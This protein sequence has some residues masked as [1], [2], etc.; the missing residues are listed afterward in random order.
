M[1]HMAQQPVLK[2]TALWSPYLG[3]IYTPLKTRP[4]DFPPVEYPPVVCKYKTLINP[5]CGIDI[6]SRTWTCQ[7]HTTITAADV[8]SF[9]LLTS[10]FRIAMPIFNLEIFIWSLLP[11]PLIE[12]LLTLLSKELPSQKTTKL[13]PAHGLRCSGNMLSTGAVPPRF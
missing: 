7:V 1:E 5:Y 11:A 2:P 9:V 10:H 8:R 13:K 3:A 12:T 6:A 4:A